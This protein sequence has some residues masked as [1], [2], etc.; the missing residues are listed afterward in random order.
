MDLPVVPP[1]VFTLFTTIDAAH[2]YEI[3]F[4]DEECEPKSAHDAELDPGKD[5]AKSMTRHGR[6]VCVYVDQ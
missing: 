2:H 3:E 5:A 1:V 6:C 4:D